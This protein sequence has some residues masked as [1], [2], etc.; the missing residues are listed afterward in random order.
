M[1]EQEEKT[2]LAS[3]PVRK[4]TIVAHSVFAVGILSLYFYGKPIHFSLPKIDVSALAKQILDDKTFPDPK[5]PQGRCS[6]VR[7]KPWYKRGLCWQD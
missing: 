4:R 1:S 5:D 3:R 2:V 6:V 7:Q